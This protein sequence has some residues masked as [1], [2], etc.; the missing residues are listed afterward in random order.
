MVNCSR[1]GSRTRNAK[2]C[3]L[4][5]WKPQNIVF[6]ALL[7]SWIFWNQTWNLLLNVP[8]ITFDQVTRLLQGY[9][10]NEVDMNPDGTC[11]ENCGFYTLAKHHNCFKD[12]YCS[13]QKACSGRILNCGYIDSDMWVCPAVSIFLVDVCFRILKNFRYKTIDRF[14]ESLD[15]SNSYFI[16]RSLILYRFKPRPK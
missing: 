15:V 12:Q 10:E 13:K 3:A 11:R 7:S 1:H 14:L 4:C 5:L 16:T 9:V 2:T 8:G 6:L